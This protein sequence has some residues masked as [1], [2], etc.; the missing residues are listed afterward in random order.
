MFVFNG[1]IGVILIVL[2]IILMAVAAM[3]KQ[4]RGLSSVGRLCLIIGAVIFIL[5]LILRI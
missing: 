2:G 3:V 4:F 1:D 5:E